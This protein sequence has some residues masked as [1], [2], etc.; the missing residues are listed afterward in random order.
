MWQNEMAENVVLTLKEMVNNF[1]CYSLCLDESTNI[2]DTGQVAS[3]IRG[4]DKKANVTECLHIKN[5][6]AK[7]IQFENVISTVN[8][9]QKHWKERK[10]ILI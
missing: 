10:T 4:V 7:N 5:L 1:I 6:C 3:F 8:L 9:C 2:S